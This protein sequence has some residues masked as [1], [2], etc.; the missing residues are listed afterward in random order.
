MPEKIATILCS[1][2]KF[3]ERE[4]IELTKTLYEMQE[5]FTE[6]KVCLPKYFDIC[7]NIDWIYD[8]TYEQDKNGHIEKVDME[9]VLPKR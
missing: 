6:T 5:I 3:T 1:G 2:P 8:F 9:Q 4:S 7:L